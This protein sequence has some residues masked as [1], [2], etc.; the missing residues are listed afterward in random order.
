MH[1]QALLT[2][3]SHIFCK[4]TFTSVKTKNKSSKFAKKDG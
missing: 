2:P 1:F 4:I 3:F